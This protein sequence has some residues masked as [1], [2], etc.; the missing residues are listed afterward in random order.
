MLQADTLSRCYRSDNG[1]THSRR[2]RRRS[3]FGEH[4]SYGAQG[5]VDI[6]W[7]GPP[8]RDRDRQHGAPV[9]TD[10]VIHAVPFTSSRRATSRVSSSVANATQTWVK[11][12]SL[13]TVARGSAAKPSANWRAR[14]QRP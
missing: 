10:Y 5:A 11:S 7:A 12:T 4:A 8:V 2:G 1:T 3:D 14:A 13:S 9:Q 6:G